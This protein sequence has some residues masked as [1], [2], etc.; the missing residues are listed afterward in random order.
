MKKD[1]LTLEQN[2]C[3]A[4]VFLNLFDLVLENKENI[5]EFTKFGIFDRNGKQVGMLYFENDVVKIQCTTSLGFLNA[6]YDMSELSCFMDL[7][8]GGS[9]VQWNHTI[10]FEVAGYQNFSGNMQLDVSMDSDLDNT[11]RLHTIIKYVDKDN[12][13]VE[14]KLMEDGKA[15]CYETKKD[16]FREVLYIN[17]WDD[18]ESFMYH[19][20]WNGK[21]DNVHHCFPNE[22]IR[23]VRNNGSRDRNH[24]RTVSHVTKKLQ[25]VEY[26]DNLYDSLG[27][28]ESAESTIQKGLLMQ[29]IDP[30]FS[31]KIVELINSFKKEDVS[32]LEN[33][34]DISFNRASEEE[35]S[36]LF[37]VDIK[38]MNHHKE[39]NQLTK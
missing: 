36:A 16:D 30:N 7:K 34:I 1:Y 22:S 9:F 13:E 10:K 17:P 31:K 27:E 8:F 24:L 26:K 12:R 6:N 37:G 5:D 33:L 21:Y 14:L 38:R 39:G 18:L 29:K 15:F 25:T 23:F 2:L 28:E 32:F 35:R 20:I 4:R 11:C 19:I 3:C